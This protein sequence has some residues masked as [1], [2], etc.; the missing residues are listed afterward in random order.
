MADNEQAREQIALMMNQRQT[1]LDQA[2]NQY[3]I[4]NRMRMIHAQQAVH[5]NA[6]H[7]PQKRQRLG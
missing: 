2:I 7:R 4:D 1:M 3:M 6:P 5:P